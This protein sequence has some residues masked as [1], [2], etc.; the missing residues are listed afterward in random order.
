MRF[1][2]YLTPLALVI[3]GDRVHADGDAA[4]AFEVHGVEELVLEVACGDGAGLEQELV[5][6]R[7]LAVVDMGDDGEVADEARSPICSSSSTA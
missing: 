3:D 7:A 6:Q 2:S 5:G 1:S 4:F